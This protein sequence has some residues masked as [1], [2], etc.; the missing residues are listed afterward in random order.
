MFHLH[1]IVLRRFFSPCLSRL[2]RS[3]NNRLV[4]QPA[5]AFSNGNPRSI[6]QASSFTTCASSLSCSE[7]K[8]DVTTNDNSDESLAQWITLDRP[9]RRNAISLSMYEALA[10][11]LNETNARRDE[12][13]PSF[14]VITGTGDYF[15]AGNDLSKLIS[16][17]SQNLIPSFIARQPKRRSQAYQRTN[18]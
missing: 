10:A 11:V 4:I 7:I 14:T 6:I 8:I 17:D 15:S 18:R 13:T 12:T 16:N 5:A 1:P 3:S 9:A 2:L